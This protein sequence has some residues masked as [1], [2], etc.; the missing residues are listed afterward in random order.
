M[1]ANSFDARSTLQVGDESYEIFRLDKVEGSARLPYSLKVLL[2]N[3][4]R[5]ED[6]A[7]ITADHIRALGGWDSQAQPSQEIQFT[8]ARVIMQDFTG[9]PCVVD[10]ATMREAV[11]ELGGDPAKINPLAPA[12]LVID[13]SVI[14]DK[15]GTHEAF[16]QNVELEYGR[17]KERYQFLR[18]GQTAFDE[19]KVVPPGTGIVHQ[20]NIE[21]LARVVMV[22][23]GKAYPDTLVGT[24]SHTTMVNGLGVLGWGVGG[25][26]AEA[27]MLGQ[28]VSMLI[29]RVVGFKL[30]GEL[31]AGTTATD[32][33][34][35]ITEMLRKHGVVGKFVE[36]YGEGVAATSLANRAT[37]GNMSPEFGSTAAIFPIDDETLKYLR[38][39]G[40]SDQQVALVEAYAKEQGLW[41]D[42]KAEPDFSEKLELDLST[43]V[44]SIAG[45][46]RPQ[47]RIVLAEAAQQFAKDVLN[48][49]EAPVAQSPDAASSVVDEAS[50]ESFPASDAPAYGHQEN[51]AGAPQHGQGTGAVPSNPVTVTAPDGTS[52]ELDHGAV[53][54]AAITSCTNT[55]NP[56]VMI[57][58]ALV[59]KKA[60]EKGLTRKPWVKSTLAPGSKVVTDY[61]DKAGLTP[62]LDKLGFN[63][64]GYGCTTCIGNSG[65]LPEEVSQAVNDNDLAV[66][67]VLSGNRNFEGRINPDVKMNY[68]ASPPLVVAYA[69]AGSMKV[70]ITREP[71]GTDQDGNDVFLKDVWPSEA[72]VNE[73]VAA[74]IGEDMF[75][76][77]Y[78]DVFAG[79]AQWQSLPVP[80]GNTFEWDAEST[81]VR[82]PPYF[83]GMGTDPEPVQDI[84]GA[85]VLAKLGDS[86]TTDHISPAGAIKADTPAGRYLTEHGVERRDFNSYGSRRGNHEVM[87][88]GTFA[89]I[90]LRN[91]IAPGT[92][93]G[94]TRDFTQEGGPVAFIYDASQ[95]YQAAGTPLVVLAGKEYGSG[96]SRDWAAKGTALLGVK[97]VIAESYE[98]IHRSN[99]I[100]MGVLP[101][102]FPEGQSAESLG[103][104]GEETFSFTGVTELNDGTTP[105]TVKVT[106]D[107]G[108]EFDAVVRIDTPG[109]ADYYRNGGIMQYVLRSLIRK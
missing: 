71:L 106:T 100:G 84:S 92:E 9:V 13:H 93:G 89:N 46:K 43:V 28:P 48:Y 21:H 36:F 2:E 68:L 98:R 24:D 63:L 94:Y 90:R 11:K 88:R 50:A 23:D 49:V 70:D 5:T 25:I 41:L 12:E 22:R 37:I 86:V 53:T 95:N 67:S 73:V 47:D 26:E 81:Y 55:S 45:P 87:I 104:T 38:L 58:A 35:T 76:K 65:P 27:A 7:N 31:P 3:L 77:S 99:L 69:I 66:V 96:S 102:Q 18:W 40:R 103:L 101:L 10:L 64:V 79:D 52:Y 30:T 80:T 19:F 14:A 108:V 29:P 61:F 16:K 105:R 54:V 44:P 39:T 56:Y 60:V 62:Y 82:K 4:L 83:E 1:S 42:P 15:F 109:E 8:P 91:Q 17:N 20:V 33:V 97:A 75:A 51:G 57:G 59:A 32:L 34:L 72:E 78:S 6:G 107:T 85:R 74:A